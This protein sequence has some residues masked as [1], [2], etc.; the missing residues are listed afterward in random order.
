MTGASV[1]I[2]K[3]TSKSCVVFVVVVMGIVSYFIGKSFVLKSRK[4]I[5]T[6]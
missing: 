5:P 2:K 6:P 1:I 3:C 4:N